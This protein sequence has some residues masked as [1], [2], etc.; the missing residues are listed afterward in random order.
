MFPYYDPIVSD[1]LTLPS[2]ITIWASQA[3]VGDQGRVRADIALTDTIT[4][5]NVVIQFVLCEDSVYYG[6]KYYRFVVRD[7][8]LSES[9]SISSPGDSVEVERD[10][11]VSEDWD[12]DHLS[13]VVF[14][15]SNTTKEVLQA[16]SAVPEPGITLS[17]DQVG[18]DI[19]FAQEGD[20]LAIFN[21]SEEE[22]DSL[23]VI[24]YP[25]MLPP[26]RSPG[27]LWVYRSFMILPY[28]DTA[29]FVA[30][31]TLI[32]DQAEFDSSGLPTEGSLQLYRFNGYGWVAQGGEPDSV[33][34][35]ITLSGVTEFSPWAISD[36]NYVVEVNPAWS[37]GRVPGP[38]LLSQNYPNPFNSTTLIRYYLPAVGG[39]QPRVSLKIYNIL[40]QPVRTLVEMEQAPGAYSVVWDGRDTTGK[41]VSSGIYIYKLQAGGV[42]ETRKM[43]LLR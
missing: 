25:N 23:T 43:I 18:E 28:P 34:N 29:N 37:W 16:A 31:M 5:S 40:G 11:T 19:V 21:F 38:F 41:G 9:L 7:M 10:F 35:S 39:Q 12:P 30:T 22:L 15:Q 8:L 17:I 4:E 42:V 26:Q 36:S 2:P 3:I 6:G 20:T 33:T 24:G 14:A 27:D 1:H 13:V 32:Y